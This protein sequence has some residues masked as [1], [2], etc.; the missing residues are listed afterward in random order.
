MFQV[1]KLALVEQ[2]NGILEV[3]TGQ[4]VLLFILT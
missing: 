3:L 1:K 4:K 2:T